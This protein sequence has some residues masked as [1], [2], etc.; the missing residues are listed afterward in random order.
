MV[1]LPLEGRAALAG[2][3]GGVPLWVGR[4]ARLRLRGG[5]HPRVVEGEVP[6]LY[7]G[8]ARQLGEANRQGRGG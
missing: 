5:A 2:V 6:L 3:G 4:E 1:L 7:E 8:E